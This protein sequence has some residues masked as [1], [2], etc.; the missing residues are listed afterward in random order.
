MSSLK[1]RVPPSSSSSSK[2]R[3]RGG[4]HSKQIKKIPTRLVDNESID[5]I[6]SPTGGLP[7]RTPVLSADDKTI[8]IERLRKEV[9][10]K[11]EFTLSKKRQRDTSI[12]LGGNADTVNENEN[13]GHK[14]KKGKRSKPPA[15]ADTS[16]TE[17]TLSDIVKKRLITGTNQCTRALEA[18]SRGTGP[19]PYLVFLSRDVR[20]PTILAHIPILCQKMGIPALVLPGRASAELGNALGGRSVAVAVFLPSTAA[21]AAIPEGQQEL[22]QG[23]IRECCRCIDS[24]VKFALSKVPTNKAAK[25]I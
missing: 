19:L 18:A 2:K 1:S 21:A 24:Y 15:A 9:V 8:L 4:K 11:F 22:C 13:D 16:S 5:C 20:P 25:D 23:D 12:V 14:R 17:L 6:A 7:I 3:G 10:E